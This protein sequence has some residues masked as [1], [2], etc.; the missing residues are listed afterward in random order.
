MSAILSNL[1]RLLQTV[2]VCSTIPLAFSANQ[3]QANEEYL[4]ERALEEGDGIQT[5]HFLKGNYHPGVRGDS[6][7]DSFIFEKIVQNVAVHLQK[8]DFLPV[9]PKEE[10]H[11]LIVVST[12]LSFLSTQ[13]DSPFQPTRIPREHR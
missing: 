12:Q 8:Q 13:S 4:N 3:M 2:V 5:Y 1:K 7:M 10:A 6:T 11:L 9:Q